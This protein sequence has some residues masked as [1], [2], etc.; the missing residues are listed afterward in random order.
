MILLALACTSTSS[1]TGDSNCD[2]A[3]TLQQH[4]AANENSSYA[5]PY[6][7]G[8]CTSDTFQIASNDIPHFEFVAITPN[9]LSE[10][11]DFYEIP[12]EGV[13]ASSP[14]DI[15]F[16]GEVA[17]TVTGLR[18]YGPNEGP[19]PDAYGDPVIAW[20]LDGFPIY[21]PRGCADADCTEIVEYESGWETTG[22]P[23]TYAWDNHEY[24]GGEL[25]P[26]NGHT[27]PE[28]DYHYHATSAFPYVLGCYAGEL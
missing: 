21:G 27:G 28:G 26:C 4:D 20:S 16:L 22:D 23:T 24:V 15:A 13:L 2:Q 8:A 11:D 12:L 19:E 18:I 1:L 14:R 9:G 25:D 6:V 17:V 10:Q 7:E 3:A 5:A